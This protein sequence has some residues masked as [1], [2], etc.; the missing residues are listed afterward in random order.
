MMSV[1]TRLSP[2]LLR[3]RH[4][5]PLRGSFASCAHSEVIRYHSAACSVRVRGL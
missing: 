3:V 5:Y 2:S 1:C 4:I